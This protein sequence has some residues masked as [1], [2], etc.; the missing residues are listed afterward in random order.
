MKLDKALQ[1]LLEKNTLDNFI[2]TL[3]QVVSW[4][5]L[6]LAF[7]NRCVYRGSPHHKSDKKLYKEWLKKAK[8]FHDAMEE[9]TSKGDEHES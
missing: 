1:K 5:K 9:S 7:S 6:M 8:M 3:V 2:D 4:D